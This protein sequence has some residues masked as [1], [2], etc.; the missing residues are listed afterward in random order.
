MSKP[1]ARMEQFYVTQ[2]EDNLFEIFDRKNVER[3][4]GT[5]ETREQA[6]RSRSKRKFSI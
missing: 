4:L 2:R 3:I 6:E 1:R 5:Y